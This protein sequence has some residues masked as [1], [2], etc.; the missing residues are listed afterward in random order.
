MAEAGVYL[1]VV[2]QD[3]A[4]PVV[5]HNSIRR[6]DE[7]GRTEVSEQAWDLYNS[8]RQ[9]IP[10][11]VAELHLSPAISHPEKIPDLRAMQHGQPRSGA[12]QADEAFR[13]LSTPPTARGDDISDLVNTGGLISSIEALRP[14]HQPWRN[15]Q[16]DWSRQ[17][18]EEA[19]DAV[20]AIVQPGEAD[21]PQLAHGTMAEPQ[22]S[23]L[24]AAERVS[25]WIDR[26]DGHW[27]ALSLE[28]DDVRRLVDFVRIVKASDPKPSDYPQT[29][30][31]S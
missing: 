6:D 5:V 31:A 24:D 8:A 17:G 2:R 22:G 20:L 14:K 1:C 18:Y 23:I 13:L 7:Q 29:G 30:D 27:S 25:Q 9:R 28:A 3:S 4:L 15:D 16:E 11:T 21:L 10:F 12:D 19:I 26:L